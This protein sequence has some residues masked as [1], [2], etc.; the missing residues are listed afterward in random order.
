M[1]AGGWSSLGASRLSQRTKAGTSRSN[2]CV[3]CLV[4][5]TSLWVRPAELLHNDG[6]ALLTCAC[7]LYGSEHMLTL[8]HVCRA[9]AKSTAVDVCIT[10]MLWQRALLWMCVSIL[11]CAKDYCS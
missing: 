8:V 2:V 9:L 7:S 3:P 10:A 6:H 11:C 5:H 1:L 4:P